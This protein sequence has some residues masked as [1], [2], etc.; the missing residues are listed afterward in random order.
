MIL[1]E[2]PIS[3]VKVKPWLKKAWRYWKSLELRGDGK[4]CMVSRTPNGTSISILRSAFTQGG[5]VTAS[6]G[7]YTG[8]FVLSDATEEERPQVK[9][10]DATGRLT[11]GICGIFVSG[12]D[13]VMVPGKTLTVTQAGVVLL[14]AKYDKSKSEW[15]VDF[16][17]E[18]ELPDF[19]ADKF[20][21]LLGYVSFKDKKIAGIT[22]IWNNG[23]IYNNRYS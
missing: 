10:T 11:D 8:F 15:T 1:P 22:Q 6:D 13:K 5:G 21:A 18:K 2:E 17:L 20:T 3:G 4:T 9:I 19:T 7:A 16:K 23:I 12:I 14:E